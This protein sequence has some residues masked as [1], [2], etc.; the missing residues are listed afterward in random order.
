ME[1]RLF[2]FESERERA[3]LAGLRAGRWPWTGECEVS[4]PPSGQS[5]PT[6]LRPE[7]SNIFFKLTE[8]RYRKKSKTLSTNLD[9]DDWFAFLGQKLMVQSLL[10]RLRHKRQSL[11]IDGPSLRPPTG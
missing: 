3:R 4:Y 11:H 8:K 10:D 1:T 2:M 9:Y 6:S 5:S 7:Q